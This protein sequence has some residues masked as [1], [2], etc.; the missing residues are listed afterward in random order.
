MWKINS[1]DVQR[2]KERTELRRAEIE[3]KYNEE[4]KALNAEVEAMETLERVAGEFAQKFAKPGNGEAAA[5]PPRKPA[6]PPAT[7]TPEP[8]VASAAADAASSNNGENKS[9]SRWRL[10]LGNRPGEVEGATPVA[11][12]R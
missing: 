5:A 12:P 10:H 1:D 7:P 3:T 8:V 4:M 2:A 6:D 11:A 9:G